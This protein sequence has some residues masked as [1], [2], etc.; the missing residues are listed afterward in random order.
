MRYSPPA[1]SL[2]C[3]A[4]NSID[5]RKKNPGKSLALVPCAASACTMWE[6]GR[7]GFLE[8]VGKNGRLGSLV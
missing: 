3:A 2:W 8:R 6:E 7:C 1:I 4:G 5:E